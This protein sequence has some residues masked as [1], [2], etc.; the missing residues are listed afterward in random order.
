MC[1]ALNNQ[2]EALDIK[3]QVGV[4]T[5]TS[6]P[7]LINYLKTETG[8]AANNYNALSISNII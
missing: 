5:Q 7:I 3:L 6:G 8:K 1:S 4:I 2:K